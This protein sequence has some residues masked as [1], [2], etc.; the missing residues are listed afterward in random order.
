MSKILIIEDNE[1]LGRMY[2][3]L[4][5]LENFQAEWVSSGEEGVEKAVSTHPDLILCDVIMPKM[6]GIQVLEK[7]KANPLTMGIQVIML[8]VIGEKEIID[9]CIK[10]GAS[11]YIIKSNLNLDQLLTEIRTYLKKAS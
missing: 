1:Y 11:G 5:G 4:L 3:N 9:K 7:L 8:T 10:L 6:N 2:Q